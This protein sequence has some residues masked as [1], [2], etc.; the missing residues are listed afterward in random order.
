MRHFL[1]VARSPDGSD[2]LRLLTWVRGLSTWVSIVWLEDSPPS[3]RARTVVDAF[4]RSAASVEV[5][6]TWPGTEL[7]DETAVRYIAPLSDDLFAVIVDAAGGLAEWCP[8]ALPEDLHF[9]RED[10][11]V[12]L[13]STSSEEYAWLE[14]D[15]AERAALDKQLVDALVVREPAPPQLEHPNPAWDVAGDSVV[16]APTGLPDG[17]RERL[18]CRRLDDSR[19]EVCCIPF[20]TPALALGDVIEA[21]SDAEGAWQLTRVV[22]RHGRGVA[23]VGIR[24]DRAVVEETQAALRLIG[25]AFENEGLLG[26][27]VDI[28]DDEVGEQ[29]WSCLQDLEEA[30]RIDLAYLD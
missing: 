20:H 30:G 23:W 22:E 26:L 27:V 19:F 12:V 2:Y 10:Q 13:G 9:M 1:E 28:A 4:L 21:E 7:A 8:P 17:S 5:T 15:D 25:A 3:G 24:H 16:S 6:D 11:S 29:A 14:L 18:W